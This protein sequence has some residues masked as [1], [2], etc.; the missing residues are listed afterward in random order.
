MNPVGSLFSCFHFVFLQFH[1][2]HPTCSV[3]IMKPFGSLFSC[4]CFRFSWFQFSY[5]ASLHLS[6]PIHHLLR[7]RTVTNLHKAVTIILTTPIFM[8]IVFIYLTTV[9]ANVA[10]WR[11]FAERQKSVT[12]NCTA[13]LRKFTLTFLEGVWIFRVWMHEPYVKTPQFCW[14]SG[15]WFWAPMLFWALVSV[16]PYPLALSR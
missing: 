9:V 10:F 8:F 12:I 3:L 4:L 1:S 15:L 2:C 7:A 16:E 6:Y 13:L 14:G 11:L 5:Q